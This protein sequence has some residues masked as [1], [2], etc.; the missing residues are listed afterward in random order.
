MKKIS[1]VLIIMFASC[2]TEKPIH[3]SEV[4]LSDTVYSLN[5]TVF[6]VEEMLQKHKG[7]KVLID[8]WASWCGDCIKGLSSL[9]NLQNEYPEVVFLFLSVDENKDAWR[10]GIER[11]QIKGAHTTCQKE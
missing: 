9:R 10:K 8:V 7:K 3:F 4:A 5:N 1:L 11:F 6:T 2:T